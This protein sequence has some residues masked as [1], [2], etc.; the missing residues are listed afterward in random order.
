MAHKLQSRAVFQEARRIY[1]VALV[2]KN[3]TVCKADETDKYIASLWICR[4]IL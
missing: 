2:V 4:K 1:A 3:R